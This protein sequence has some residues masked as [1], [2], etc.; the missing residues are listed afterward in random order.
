MRYQG[1]ISNWKDDKGYGF[2]IQNG[3]S[4]PVFA[5]IKSFSNRQRRP[6]GDEI[7][8]YEITTDANGR[9][10]AENIEFVSNRPA[11]SGSAKS[12]TLTL[13]LAA[14]FLAFVA[15]A[16]FIGKLPVAVLGLYL[17]G[18]LLA[19][20]AY[21]SDKSAAQNGQW[22]TK[23]DTL[24]LLSLIGGW[25]GALIAQKQLRHKSSKES[26]QVVFWGTVVVNCGALGWL[27]TPS[28]HEALHSLLG[29]T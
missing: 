23:E 16:T 20:I 25:P 2:V 26:F 17:V 3:A 28:G 15:I 10:S 13:T 24:H 1:R 14:A 27:L 4:E 21:A 29:M 19:Y 6:S 8:S 12:G 11:S 9:K 7:V 5:H 18:S 22:R